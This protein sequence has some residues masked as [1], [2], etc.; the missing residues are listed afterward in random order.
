MAWI[1][2]VPEGAA[3]EELAQLYDEARD[4]RTGQLDNIMQIHSL[5]PAGL[6]AHL[7]LYGAVMGGSP[8][9]PK[10]ERELIAVVVSQL[11]DCH[12]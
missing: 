2:T 3:E 12:Y 8:S 5:K 10:V 7:Q 6:A 9:L 1:R 4:P 11:N